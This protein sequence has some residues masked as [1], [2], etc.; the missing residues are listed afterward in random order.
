[1]ATEIEKV[2][3]LGNSRGTNFQKAN[4]KFAE[5]DGTIG[6]IQQQLGLLDQEIDEVAKNA[7]KIDKI[8]V[9]GEEAPIKDKVATISVSDDFTVT[10]S[11]TTGALTLSIPSLEQ[12]ATQVELSLNGTTYELTA[13]LKDKNGNVISES[14]AV[15]LP[16]EELVVGGSYDKTSKNI[17]L[18]LKNETDIPIELDDLTDDLVSTPSATLSAGNIIIGNGGKTVSVSSAEITDTIS[19]TNTNVPTAGAVKTYIDTN[20]FGET[21]YNFSTDTSGDVYV[22]SFTSEDKIL[23]P[24]FIISS[25]GNMVFVDWTSITNGW[26][27]TSDIPLTGCDAHFISLAK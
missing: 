7:G 4:E 17:I 12:R 6:T 11:D 21:V 27:I 18:H 5:I 16:L 3:E 26:Q 22:K 1:M 2:L 14:T 23:C 10:K 19:S 15:D 13:K 8:T 24:L 25:A 9:G 20:A